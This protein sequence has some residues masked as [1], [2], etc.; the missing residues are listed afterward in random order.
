MERVATFLDGREMVEKKSNH[1]KSKQPM[2]AENYLAAKT[3]L[4]TPDDFWTLDFAEYI[5]QGDAVRHGLSRH[6]H[7]NGQLKSQGEYRMGDKV[8]LFS[9]WHSNGQKRV[10][11]EYV[12]DLRNG[13]WVWWHP[14]GQKAVIGHYD[15]G[16][17]KGRWRLWGE[18][19]LLAEQKSYDYTRESVTERDAPRLA[20]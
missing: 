11:G 14:N 5:Q 6:W 1:P 9:Y 4:K 17:A 7:P 18:D 8:G 13:D 12:N 3:V 16:E 15:Q 20:F 2:F 10:E 19:G